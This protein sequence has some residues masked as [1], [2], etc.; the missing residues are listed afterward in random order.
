MSI[1]NGFIKLT[2]M[3]PNFI[4]ELEIKGKEYIKKN[5]LLK[6]IF[7]I[8]ENTEFETTNEKEDITL[9][10]RRIEKRT[11][12]IIVTD[13]F[14]IYSSIDYSDNIQILSNLSEK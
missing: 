10:I 13:I 3:Q 11:N 6:Y 12:G 9:K 1:G 14:K 5:E 8:Q 7:K 2:V 4:E